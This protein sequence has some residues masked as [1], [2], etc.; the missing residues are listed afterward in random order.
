MML[1]GAAKASGMERDL[2]L[3]IK[4]WV[5]LLLLTPLVVANGTLFPFIVGKALYSRV[6]IEIIFGMWVILAF[7]HPA[8]RP[9]KSWILAAFGVYLG[10]SLLAGVTGVSL[11]RSVWSNYA[12]MQGVFDLAHWLALAL[13]LASILRSR[14]D[15]RL[16]LNA[17]LGVSLAVALLGGAQY[18]DIRSIPFFEF[19]RASPRLDIT[20]GNSTFVGGYMLV[21]ALI[22]LAF[23]GQS[24]L[25]RP[26]SWRPP[27]VLWRLFWGATAGLALWM[28]V[29]SGT[30]GALV[31]LVVGLVAAAAAY[32]V[33]GRARRIRIAAAGATGLLL[34]LV[35]TL[36]LVR[37]TAAFERV[38]A[39]NVMLSRI[40][41][42]G[43]EEGSIV[44]RLACQSAGIRGFADR[45]LLGWGPENFDAAFGRHFDG[46]ARVTGV[47][48]QAH[49]KL[50]EELATR[51]IVGFASYAALWAL[52][53]WA[54]ARRLRRQGA[55]EQLFTLLIGAALVGYFAQNLFLFDTPATMLQLALLVSF[56]AGLEIAESKGLSRNAGRLPVLAAFAP[57]GLVRLA[58]S[59]ILHQRW[60]AA[61]AAVGV[62]SLV[63]LSVYFLNYRPYHAARTM[64][65][66]IA[67]AIT[68]EQ[69]IGYF[70]EA[71]E[72][73]D[74][75]ANYVRQMFF[76]TVADNW[77]LFAEREATMALAIADEQAPRAL[78]AEPHG[79]LIHAAL[80]RMYQKASTPTL[81]GFS[82]ANPDEYLARA[83]LH[84][85]AA[86][87]LAP[88]TRASSQALALQQALEG[89]R[90]IPLVQESS[91]FMSVLGTP[92][93]FLDD[94]ESPI[95]APESS[96][97]P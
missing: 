81:W 6:I 75:L 5:F 63:S 7:R 52:L 96:G 91:E 49:N 39:S 27:L 8:Y 84:A 54:I 50:I 2:L 56:A 28:L 51:G 86:R 35:V 73:F 10:A 15:W 33:W 83:R 31:G 90:P 62:L 93:I 36:A 13:V 79:W 59:G 21:N 70:E 64:V 19:L 67:P 97:G 26:A 38:A 69:R 85:D 17:N 30:R 88:K 76:S 74:P 20:L 23:L 57:V 22:G 78:A 46:D 89:N 18:L 47:C 68:W 42:I 58:R 66:V 37:E 61:C 53:L 44:N 72:S 16:L 29:L 4:V 94:G 82:T 71:M 41:S 43:L 80:A 11:Q 95:V 65:Q 77:E 40:A 92:P 14:R 32:A 87:E 45:P 12:R 24:L 55:G 60:L 3:T 1:E 34:A 48:D 25:E 9:P